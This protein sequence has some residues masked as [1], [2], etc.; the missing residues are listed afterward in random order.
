MELSSTSSKKFGI[1]LLYS[2]RQL[3]SRDLSVTVFSRLSLDLALTLLGFGN[4]TRVRLATLVYL[5]PPQPSPVFSKSIIISMSDEKSLYFSQ[6]SYFFNN[7]GRTLWK[8]IFHCKNS[9]L[10]FGCQLWLHMYNRVKYP[11]YGNIVEKWIGLYSK[12]GYL[13]TSPYRL[14]MVCINDKT[15][16]VV[17]FSNTGTPYC[18]M[19]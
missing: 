1:Y 10:N 16:A 6:S 14:R 17:G 4:K 8:Y 3:T 5:H 7:C 9:L 19:W 12:G 15:H 11:H 13:Y 18:F 2:H